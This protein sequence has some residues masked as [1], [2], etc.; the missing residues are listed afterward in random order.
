MFLGKMATFYCYYKAK[1]I[2]SHF[3]FGQVYNRF[4]QVLF[5]LQLVE[6]KSYFA[7]PI[8]ALF[9]FRVKSSKVSKRMFNLR[10]L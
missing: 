5:L 3:R 6:V 8:T 7:P 9:T 2:F 10:E 4:Q 1:K